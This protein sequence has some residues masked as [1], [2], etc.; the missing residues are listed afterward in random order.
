VIGDVPAITDHEIVGP[1][2]R[3]EDIFGA[4]CLTP[5]TAPAMRALAALAPVSLGLMHGPAHTGDWRKALFDPNTDID[6]TPSTL[7]DLIRS[8]KG[9]RNRFLDVPRRPAGRSRT[10]LRHRRRGWSG[11]GPVRLGLRRS[12]ARRGD[13]S[14]CAPIGNSP[15]TSAL[16]AVWWVCG[17]T[18]ARPEL[19]DA[20]SF[21]LD[22]PKSRAPLVAAS[23]S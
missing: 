7:S 18:S 22:S 13:A 15:A 12:P 4:T 21:S 8:G 20:R 2:L 23:N 14:T 10:R 1:A 3:A 6:K 17:T 16:P 19:G 11:C 9:A 5:S